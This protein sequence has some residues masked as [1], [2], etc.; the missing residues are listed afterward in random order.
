M[1]YRVFIDYEIDHRDY[2]IQ[3]LTIAGNAGEAEENCLRN[4]LTDFKLRF[5]NSC[6]AQLLT[7]REYANLK[8]YASLS[9]QVLKE[10]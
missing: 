4:F 2:S 1:Y 3:Y 5:A 6:T 7:Y 8:K 10:I 9:G